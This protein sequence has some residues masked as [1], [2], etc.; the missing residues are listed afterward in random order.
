MS[1]FVPLRLDVKLFILL[2]V[3]LNNSFYILLFLLVFIVNR[4]NYIKL[5]LIKN[6]T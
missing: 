1:I 5:I 6:Y 3:I 4:G 2:S